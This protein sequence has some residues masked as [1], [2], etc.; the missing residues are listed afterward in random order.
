[1]TGYGVVQEPFRGFPKIPR[2]SRQMIVTEKID[3]TNASIR[4][5]PVSQRIE[6]L[7]LEQF[8]MSRE[9]IGVIAPSG[10]SF[11]LRAGSRTRWLSLDQDNFGFFSWALQNCHELLKLGEGHHF[12]EWPG[13]APGLLPRGAGASG[14][15][16]FRHRDGRERAG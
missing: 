2:L 10:E 14:G 3:G 6:R 1:M 5:T 8:T 9:D 4:V 16:P 15:L 7:G 13:G 12:G 11:L